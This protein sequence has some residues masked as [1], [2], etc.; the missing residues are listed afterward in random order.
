MS[1]ATFTAAPA[2]RREDPVLPLLVRQRHTGDAP[3]LRALMLHGLASGSSVW[4]PLWRHAPAELDSWVADLPWRG[5]HVSE[6][7]RQSDSPDWMAACLEAVP[8]AVDVVVAHSFSAN[9]LLDHLSRAAARGEDPC[10]VYGIRGI[11]LVSPFYRRS[12][13]DFGWDAV[14]G[15]QRNFL[16]IT[17][18]G[19]RLRPGRP[20]DPEILR[21]MA[22][23][24]CERAGLYGWMRFLN[25]YLH[26]PW[27]HTGLIDVPALVVT[28]TEDFA[29]AESV[30]LAADLPAA[31]LQTLGGCGHY[32][33][34]EQPERFTALLGRF[35]ESL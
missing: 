29:A 23:R 13:D 2:A 28:G 17:E 14:A 34:F 20:I 21:D 27:L 18:E 19:I 24:V 30:A 16:A 8:G 9:L 31:E 6:W 35:V 10:A 25:L 26:T 5:D 22:R 32:P 3:R 4:D 15:M 12:P 11:V 7:G 33:M 1:S